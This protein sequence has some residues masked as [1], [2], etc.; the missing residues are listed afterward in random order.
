MP[1]GSLLPRPPSRSCQLNPAT[2]PRNSLLGHEKPLSL[3]SLQTRATEL[4]PGQLAS[5]WR[6][7]RDGVAEGSAFFRNSDVGA[8]STQGLSSADH[9]H[10][11]NRSQ[12]TGQT[13]QQVP[14]LSWEQI[15]AFLPTTAPVLNPWVE[16]P[17]G[18]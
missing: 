11:V 2:W 3:R 12:F 1:S 16:T 18:G 4:T 6:G 15:P 8:H 7:D 13:H 9:S 14:G 5:S 17:S 10:G